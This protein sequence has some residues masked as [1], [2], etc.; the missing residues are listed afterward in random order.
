MKKELIRILNGLDIFL[1]ELDDLNYKNNEAGTDEYKEL[2]DVFKQLRKA[3][4]W[5][6]EYIDVY[7]K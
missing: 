5:L 3:S 2:E 1:N 4:D 6:E 7:T